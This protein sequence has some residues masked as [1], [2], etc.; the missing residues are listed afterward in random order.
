M[1]INK[2]YLAQYSPLPSN[3]DIT[4]LVPYISTAEKIWVLPIIGEALYDELEEQVGSNTLSS[5]NAT[6]LTDGGLWQ[7]LAYATLY[8]ALP[9]LWTRLTEAGIVLGK[10]ENADSATLKDITYI[11]QHLR[12]QTEVLKEFVIKFLCS[13]IDSYSLFDAS[14]CPQCGC[15]CNKDGEL[16]RPNPNHQL[17]R[18][19][20]DSVN[21]R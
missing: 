7:Y 11:S 20:D 21:I 10:S 17:Y 18:P 6:L 5:E 14:I 19:C 2:K 16:Q 1:I 8:E 9:L 15:G 12:R 4:N 13:H 3:F